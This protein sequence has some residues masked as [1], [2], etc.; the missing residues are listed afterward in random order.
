MHFGRRDASRGS[1]CA[2]EGAPPPA[3]GTE[4]APPTCLEVQKSKV[5]GGELLGYTLA[6]YRGL[7]RLIVTVFDH[8]NCMCDLAAATA[9]LIVVDHNR[10][11]LW[12]LEGVHQIP[13]HKFPNPQLG[14]R[15]TATRKRLAI[16]AHHAM[17]SVVQDGQTLSRGPERRA[18]L[19][20]ITWAFSCRANQVAWTPSHKHAQAPWR[21]VAARVQVHTTRHYPVA[22]SRS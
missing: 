6:E 20:S 17:R 8:N 12:G 15:L 16:Q 21:P 22:R 1:T 10:V 5:L 2:W 19:P 9:M 11:V 7:E 18:R 14:P 3:S 4:G 13:H